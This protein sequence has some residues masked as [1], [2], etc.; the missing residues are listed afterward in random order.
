MATPAFTPG[1]W[2]IDPDGG[3]ARWNIGTSDEMVAIAQE[4]LH[5]K[6]FAR[7][8][9]NANLIAAAPDLYEA[10]ETAIANLRR[11]RDTK[12]DLW[13]QI[14]DPELC[15]AWDAIKAAQAKARGEVQ[16]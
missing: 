5:D 10:L 2:R 13:D 9:A 12:P 11:L 16:S 4:L 8:D 7:R 1:E 6:G 14:V 15:S 3:L